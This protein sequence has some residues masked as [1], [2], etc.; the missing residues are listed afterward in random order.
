MTVLLLLGLAVFLAFAALALN[1][2]WLS[3]QQVRLRQACQSAALAGAAELMDPAPDV[4]LTADAVVETASGVVDPLTAA[5]VASAQQQALSFA[6]RNGAIL[7]SSA[8]GAPASDPG[9]DL[10]AGWVDDPPTPGSDFKPWSGTEPVNSLLVRA[11]RRRSRGDAVTLWFGSLFGIADAEP[12]AAARAS[13]DQR[14]YGFRPAGHVRVPLVP[15]LVFSG[16]RWPSSVPGAEAGGEDSY[17]VDP[18][19]GEVQP[20]ADGIGEITLR[21]GLAWVAPPG[22]QAAA[23]QNACWLCLTGDKANP[24]PLTQQVLQSLAAGDLVALGGQFALGDGGGLPLAAAP[25]AVAGQLAGLQQ[26]LLAIRG[27]KRIWP[28]GSLVAPADQGECRVEGFAAGCVVDCRQ[29]TESSLAVVVQP[30]TLRTCTAL[31]GSGA[32]RNPWI[33]K[34][35]LSE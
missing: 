18:R 6:A 24:G 10:V 22:D 21:T 11:V 5:R 4:P 26:A 16:S 9:E 15:L 29:E 31:V 1:L 3:C 23:Q 28:L 34:L 19:T 12:A 13:I 32:A 8:N 20:G 30:C 7:Q 14:V 2:T 33:G 17:W 35:I 27:Q 25:A